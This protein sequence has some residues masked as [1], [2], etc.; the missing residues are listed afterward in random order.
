M[1][2]R[3]DVYETVATIPDE[4][5]WTSLDVLIGRLLNIRSKIPEEYRDAAIVED[6]YDADGPGCS[7]HVAYPRPET[8]AEMTERIAR[9]NER[10]KQNVAFDEYLREFMKKHPEE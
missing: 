4:D 10:V 9:V 6:G 8:D 1:S 3:I 7:L 2:K 5:L